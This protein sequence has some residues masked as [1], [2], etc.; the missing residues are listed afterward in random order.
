MEGEEGKIFILERGFYSRNISHLFSDSSGSVRGF[1]E[2][3]AAL[4]EASDCLLQ[5]KQVSCSR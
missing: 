5:L 1:V 3:K 2:L 4:D